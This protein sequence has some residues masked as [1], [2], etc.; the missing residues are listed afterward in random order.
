MAIESSVL[1]MIEKEEGEEKMLVF[2]PLCR[3]N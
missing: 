3:G 1:G 2:T